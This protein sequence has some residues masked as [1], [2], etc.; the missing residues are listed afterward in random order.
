MIQ[1]QNSLARGEIGDR[2]AARADLEIYQQA[3]LELVNVVVA[4]EGGAS[5]APGTIFI[6]L[7]KHQGED[8]R[9]ITF[10]RSNDEEVILELGANVM[11]FVD[12]K[13]RT[14]IGGNYEVTT[15]WAEGD[16]THLYAWQ[17]ADVMFVT[18]KEGTQEPSIVV[19][20]GTT[21]WDISSFTLGDGPYEAQNTSDVTLDPSGQT[22]FITVTASED[23]FAAGDVGRLLRFYEPE[24]GIPY[25][26]WEPEAQATYG[27]LYEY[28]GRVYESRVAPGGSG[29]AGTMSNSP[30]VHEEGDV[31][32]GGNEV[33]WRY[34]HDL[35][36]QARITAYQS[37]RVV[38]AQVEK[39]LPSALPTAYWARG[40]F[41]DRA[42]WP[43]VG[44]IYEGRLFFAG[45]PSYPDTLWAT[46][47]DGFNLESGDF[48]QSAGSGE[49]LDDNAV[50]RTLNDSKV[51]P[52]SSFLA[53]E[54]IHM[55]HR[56]GPVRVG[57]PSATEPITPAGATARRRGGLPG[58]YRAFDALFAAERMLYASE[59]GY[60]LIALDPTDYSYDNLCTY[61]REKM[62]SP[63]KEVV[64]LAE[65][66]RRLI[67]LTEDGRLFSMTFDPRLRL[68]GRTT[69]KLGGRWNDREPFVHSIAKARGSDNIERVFLAVKRTVNGA[70]Q[71]TIEMM[72]DDFESARRRQ[73]QAV[74]GDSS[75]IRSAWDESPIGSIALL[76]ATASNRGDTVSFSV[77]GFSVPT[78]W[79][80]QE[81]WLRRSENPIAIVMARVTA[82]GASGF[83]AELLTDFDP[84][85]VGLSLTEFARPFASVA[86]L[87]HLEGEEVGIWA[88]G[89]DRG[90]TTVT[91]AQVELPEPAAYAVVGLPRP[92]K[93]VSLDLILASGFGGTTRG[94]TL[95]PAA[96]YLRLFETGADEGQVRL[97]SGKRPADAE[98]L[99]PRDA[100]DNVTEVTG[101][102]EG[103]VKVPLSSGWSR[104]VKLEVFGDGMAPMTITGMA[105]GDD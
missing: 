66:K 52:I 68:A 71:T 93:I 91:G 14:F 54:E 70:D 39:E 64:Y 25:E 82:I 73:E 105:V 99:R 62:G 38:S 59:G 57:G 86:G 74:Y 43:F 67:V 27:E 83:D 19:R 44:G 87:P 80:G 28:E 33:I 96:A 79:E 13:T 17:S 78:A 36:G 42:G 3:A 30:P 47:T 77:T 63:L 2:T 41:C 9:L 37:A 1:W 85:M 40:Y 10:A 16:L 22:G 18:H 4:P 104:E 32:D 88:D 29:Q 55:F 46:R 76:G 75:V 5:R 56:G 45:S 69:L 35:S 92:W 34:R 20:F 89:A 53:G 26:K 65:D 84:A 7:A 15:P 21:D 6:G 58:A 61:F 11:R 100:D 12:P 60:R 72:E 98:M 95:N 50:V 31:G 102:R 51:Y 49:V 48:L 24:L 94:K 103:I 101:L 81:I 97:I 23:M 8:V 90:R